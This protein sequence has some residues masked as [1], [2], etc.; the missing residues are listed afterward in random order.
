[1]SDVIVAIVVDDCCF[2]FPQALLVGKLVGHNSFV[3]K[4]IFNF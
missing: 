3:S 2:C 1:M 4:L